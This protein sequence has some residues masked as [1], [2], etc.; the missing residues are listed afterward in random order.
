[1][2]FSRVT[3]ESERTPRALAL[4]GC[5]FLLGLLLGA[6]AGG[7]GHGEAPRVRVVNRSAQ[8]VSGLWVR[9]EKDSVRVPGLQPGESTEVRVRVKGEAL[10]WVSGTVNG[11]PVESDGGEYVEGSGGYRFRATIDSTGHVDLEFIRIR[12]Y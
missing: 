6:A 1:M 8:R 5:V 3:I 10:L 11:R 2:S 9:T 12:M 4:A 7:C